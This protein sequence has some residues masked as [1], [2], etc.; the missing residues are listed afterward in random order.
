MTHPSDAPRSASLVRAAGI[1]L[2]M[3]LFGAGAIITSFLTGQGVARWHNLVFPPIVLVFAAIT[4]RLVL[5]EVRALWPVL[6]ETQHKGE[7]LTALGVAIAMTVIV[8][9]MLVIMPFIFFA[10]L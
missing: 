2:A 8:G 4:M 10:A 7:A 5:A 6:P 9:P 1:D 3:L